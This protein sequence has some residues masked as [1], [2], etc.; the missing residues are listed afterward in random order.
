M[1]LDRL[2]AGKVTKWLKIRKT[3]TASG[4][5]AIIAIRCTS[6]QWVSGI[7]VGKNVGSIGANAKKLQ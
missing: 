5:S 3:I 7:V 1:S 6:R 2:V 4:I